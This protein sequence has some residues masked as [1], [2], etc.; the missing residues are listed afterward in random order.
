MAR[1]YSTV[2]A[3][4]KRFQKALAAPYP[5]VLSYRRAGGGVRLDDIK[6][7]DWPGRAASG[8][9]R[10]V[11]SQMGRVFLW[12]PVAFG[13]GAAL[14]LIL[15]FE[16]AWIWVLVPFIALIAAWIFMRRMAVNAYV[17]NLV[18]LLL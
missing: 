17:L 11:A 7:G 13:G 8:L 18:L 10:S 12:L 3:E 6:I 4:Q 1:A 5:G 15:P 14:Y 16:P 2:S 9:R